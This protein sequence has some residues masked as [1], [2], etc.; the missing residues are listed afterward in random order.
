MI[1]RGERAR[2][3]LICYGEKNKSKKIAIVSHYYIIGHII[4]DASKFNEKGKPF[5]KF[6]V[7]NAEPIYFDIDLAKKNKF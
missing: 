6:V 7:P 4:N 1:G 2:Q 5:S 3:A